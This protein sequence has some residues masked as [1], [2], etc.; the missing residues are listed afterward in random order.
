MNDGPPQLIELPNMVKLYYLQFEQNVYEM[1]EALKEYVYP[2]Y[3]QWHDIWWNVF[4][5][6]YQLDPELS[7][8]YLCNHFDKA[9][10]VKFTDAD[11]VRHP[12]V[13]GVVRAYA[14][15]ESKLNMNSED[16]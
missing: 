3:S 4:N 10:F 12:L 11:V 7:Y 6:C 8:S 9:S 5:K 15:R 13:A 2:E 16:E 1:L 14:K